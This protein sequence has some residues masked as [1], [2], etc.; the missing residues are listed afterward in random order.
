[1]GVGNLCIAYIFAWGVRACKG[2]GSGRESAD[3]NSRSKAYMGMHFQTEILQMRVA[4]D[5]HT[6]DQR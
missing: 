3:V 2:Q 5:G 1:M 4:T 6:S